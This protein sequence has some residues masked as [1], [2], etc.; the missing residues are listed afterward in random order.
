[1]ATPRDPIEAPLS[2]RARNTSVGSPRADQDTSGLA[3]GMIEEEPQ[4]GEGQIFQYIENQKMG[5]GILHRS[6][7]KK[8]IL[9]IGDSL[10]CGV[11]EED[12]TNGPA[13]PR[14]IA[15]CVATKLGILLQWRAFA[16]DGCLSNF[17]KRQF[18]PFNAD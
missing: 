16:S 2:V 12:L 8:H 10:F 11:G 17:F 15:S 9:F 1:M 5:G 18:T 13:L 3:M 14:T 4:V 6:E 7:K